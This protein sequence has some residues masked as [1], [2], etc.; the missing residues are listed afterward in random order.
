[1]LSQIVSLPIKNTVKICQ[2]Q[3]STNVKLSKFQKYRKRLIVS[4]LFGSLII[5]DGVFHG[6]EN[7]GK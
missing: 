4:G 2:R 6:F 5:F 3:L 7:I 1:M